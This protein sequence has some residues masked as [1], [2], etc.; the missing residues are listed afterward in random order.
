[1]IRQTCNIFS[2]AATM[3]FQW[4]CALITQQALV[5]LLQLID[6]IGA[7]DDELQGLRFYRL[8]IKIIGSQAHRLDGVFL[9][10]VAG[11]DDYLGRGR[12][13]ERFFER[14]EPFGN[15]LG[16]GRQTEILQYDRRFEAPQLRQRRFTILG[17]QHLV[18]LEAPAQLAL[19]SR[20]I[21]DDEQCLLLIQS[22]LAQR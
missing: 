2:L 14:R 6:L 17:D 1:M 15:A 3:P 8:L 12:R 22:H 19:Q 11:H 18:V 7:I 13:G 16:I 10:T 21:L 4:R 5:F 20:V 9:V